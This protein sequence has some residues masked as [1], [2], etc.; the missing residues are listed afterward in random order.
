MTVWRVSRQSLRPGIVGRLA[1][2]KPDQAAVQ[3]YFRDTLALGR[4]LI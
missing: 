3:A 2:Q 4:R 1:W